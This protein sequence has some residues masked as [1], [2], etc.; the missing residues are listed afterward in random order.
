MEVDQTQSFNQKLSQ[1]IASQGF[2]FQLRHSMSGGGGWA[3]T[4]SHLL[5]L[6][7]KVLIAL[8]VA[9]G[10][11]GVYLV[12][13]VDAESFAESLDAS[14][15][16]SL[17]AKDA[18]LLGFSRIQGDAQITR[19]GAEGGDESFFR[20][21]DAG[22]VR[23]KMD[24][25]DGI[26]GDWD[27]GTLIAKWMELDL[28]AGA[29]TPDAAARI[30]ES[31]FREWPKFQFSSVEVDDATLSWGYH[32]PLPQNRID[33]RGRIEH[34]RM[35]A[36]RSGGGWRLV[37]SG[38][39]FSQNWLQGL[40]IEKLVMEVMPG[41]LVVKEGNFR[42]GTGT[43]TFHD[44]SVTGGD[45]P[46]F[47]G[48]VEISRVEIAQLLPKALEPFLEGVLSGNFALSGS[49]NAAG[50][51]QL[52]GDVT[53]GGDSVVSVRERLHLL[54]SLS[55]VD[56]YNSYRKIDFNRGSFHLKSS[57]G[58]LELSRVDLKADELMTLQGR[59]KVRPPSEKEMA[60]AVGE[61]PGN[62]F[63][64]IFQAG[65]PAGSNEAGDDISLRK[66]AGE[67]KVTQQGKEMEI[68]N[69]RAQVKSEEQ[70]KMDAIARESQMLR[71]EG[72]FRITIPGDAFERVEVLRSTF[73]ADA[74]TG[75][76]PI[77]VPIQGTIYEVTRR[78]AEELLE[79]GT[80]H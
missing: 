2:W 23:F 47:H 22:N 19:F 38:G 41:S 57:G 9:A 74:S 64:P 53:L 30:G 39:K 37:F 40:E 6:G 73:P 27:A 48:K 28:K 17:G 58:V 61:N 65:T 72:D 45:K 49:T 33:T 13:R 54:K 8:L 63:A 26:A 24:L 44:V 70:F 32:S 75:R 66:A 43:V 56:V 42:C 50:G 3:M 25:L 16:T 55:V 69:R 51:I 5:R 35:A 77:D 59:L 80:K 4:L 18:K 76:I 11:F 21:V 62:S 29:D 7:F 34:S 31:L 12:K 36:T 67:P 15:K 10:G 71:Y 68:F 52:E 1:W 20:S 14:V 60:G 78:Q 79:I 46:A